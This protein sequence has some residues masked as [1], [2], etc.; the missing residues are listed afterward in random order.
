MGLLE[1]ARE[2]FTLSGCTV[3]TEF[4][5]PRLAHRFARELVAES[6]DSRI[7]YHHDGLEFGAELTATGSNATLHGL[8]LILN[9]PQLFRRVEYITGCCPIACFAGRIYRDL[10]D[11]GHHLDWH[12]DRQP[13]R[14]AGLSINLSPEP[15][16]GGVFRMRA[17]QTRNVLAEVSH[18]QTGSA[19]LFRIS[20]E[21]EHCVTEVHGKAPRTAF[22]GWFQS[23]PD[24]LSL[25]RSFYRQQ[26]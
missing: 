22:A 7:H 19:H 15:Y 10:P 9:N 20:P 18:V 5:E 2:E 24:R 6:Y 26:G 11:S 14:L 21:A 17:K 1:M 23:Y 4:L 13:H 3:L 25:F 8:H 12:D 16:Q